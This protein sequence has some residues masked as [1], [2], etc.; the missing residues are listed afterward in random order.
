MPI[1]VLPDT[2]ELVK[3]PPVLTTTPRPAHDLDRFDVES[4]LESD[5]EDV[6]EPD[7]LCVDAELADPLLA[8]PL[9]AEAELD[10]ELQ[11]DELDPPDAGSAHAT[12]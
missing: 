9:P 10:D 5:P 4:S 6:P 2:L 11:P 8:A 3:A 12:P 7:E 1:S